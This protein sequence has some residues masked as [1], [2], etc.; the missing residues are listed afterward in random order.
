MVGHRWHLEHANGFIWTKDE[1]DGYVAYQRYHKHIKGNATCDLVTID[2][3]G[4][5]FLLD[6]A[7]RVHCANKDMVV[8]FDD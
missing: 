6:S 5:P 8:V 4:R 3:D 1:L 7:D 2:A